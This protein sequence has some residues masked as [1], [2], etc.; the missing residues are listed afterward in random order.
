MALSR[1]DKV[2]GV[3]NYFVELP[4]T[5]KGLRTVAENAWG[6]DPPQAQ[7]AHDH[8]VKAISGMES[9]LKD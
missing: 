8:H 5:F 1:F 6:K 4:E 3:S 2:R 9:A 7:D